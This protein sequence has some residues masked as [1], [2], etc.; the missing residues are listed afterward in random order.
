MTAAQLPR[1]P[2]PMPAFLRPS[3][4]SAKRLAILIGFALTALG[5][6]GPQFYVSSVEDRSSETDQFAK[7]LTSRIETL[8]EAQSQYLLFE[9]MGVLVYALNASGLAAAGSSQHDT[10]SNLYQLSLV[11]RSTSVRQM[12]G[13]LARAKQLTYRETSDKYGALIATARKD[14]SL[15]S[16]QAVDD[17]ET[18]TMRQADAL[19]A[20]LQDS[21]LSAE[22]TKV[23]LDSLA[24]RRKLQLIVIMTLGS[25]LLLAANL[26][27]EKPAP[28]AETPA[29]SDEAAAAERLIELAM[30]ESKALGDGK[31][32]ETGE[33]LA[34]RRLE[35][36]NVNQPRA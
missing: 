11:D 24:A 18:Q 6:L 36:L 8:R 3:F 2:M 31:I 30:R 27:S 15:A 5:T 33:T 14:V 29:S 12:I 1:A 9:Q 28:Q 4:W 22:R 13:E 35:A 23:E 25:T 16:Y 17:F 21:L 32:A 19:M 34:S 7:T 20:R 26:M 10:L